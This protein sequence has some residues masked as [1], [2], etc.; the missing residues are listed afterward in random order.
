MSP[1]ITERRVIGDY[2]ERLKQNTQSAL[3]E[4]ICTPVMTSDQDSEEYAWIG[5]VPS[6][7]E[8]RGE[9]QFG[10]LRDIAWAVKNVK[11]QNGLLIPEKHLLYDKTG[12]VQ[13]RVNEFADATTK[14]WWILIAALIIAGESSVC[15]DGQYFFDTDHSEG[16]SGSQSNDIISTAATPASPT[17]T[18]MIDAIL[19]G[20]ETMIGFKDD[21]GEFVNEDLNEFIILT[22]KS[23]V[24]SG[25]KALSQSQIA[26][27]S[28]GES[29]ILI[30][31]DS[32]RFRVVASPR[33]SWTDKFALITPQGTQKPFIR[34]Q[35][36]PSQNGTGFNS[37][38][39]RLRTWWTDSEY[40]R[41]HDEVKVSVETERAAAYG[42]WKKACLV[43]LT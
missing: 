36:V 35:R 30:E 43:T 22:G 1:I 6:M 9:K 3:V 23:F 29:N 8:Q 25:L 13:I 24:K 19:K 5:M 11:Y 20:V 37:D 31:Q 27:G 17:A 12:Q 40:C 16:S 41:D 4:S 28:S 32:F 38:G 21:R 33:I 26:N 18:E 15:Y 14:H 7:V 2:F 10:Q 34:Q 42:D 39:I